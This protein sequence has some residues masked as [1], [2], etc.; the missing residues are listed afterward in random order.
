[1]IDGICT[2]R[3]KRTGTSPSPNGGSASTA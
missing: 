1:M 3:F 2:A